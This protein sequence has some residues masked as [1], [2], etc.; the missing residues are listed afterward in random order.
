VVLH[1]HTAEE[2][3]YDR[4]DITASTLLERVAPFPIQDFHEA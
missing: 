3:G 1:T 2:I 4:H